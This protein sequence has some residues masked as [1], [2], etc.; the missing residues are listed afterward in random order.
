VSAA[1]AHCADLVRAI[2]PDAFRAIHLARPEHRPPL[3]AL[4]AYDI[5]LARVAGSVSQ[6]M[7]GEI[8]L[9]WWREAVEAVYAGAPPRHPVAE[10]LAS[11]RIRLAVPI[12]WLTALADGRALELDPEGLQGDEA[13]EDYATTVYGSRF[14]ASAAVLGATLTE[15]DISVFAL[16]AAASEKALK[17]RNA[18]F[19]AAD[20]REL[21]QA[22]RG[23]FA[24]H[25]ALLPVTAELSAYAAR[26][27]APAGAPSAGLRA[28][29]AVAWAG[30]TGRP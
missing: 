26:L 3:L 20:V 14:R 29:L 24:G 22:A 30:L 17:S 9:A 25:Q 1:A 18:P 4:R 2:A 28:V 19:E 10:A 13:F 8:R 7:L 23:H 5:E 27:S 11:D 12:A 21:V 6:P 15:A 16:V